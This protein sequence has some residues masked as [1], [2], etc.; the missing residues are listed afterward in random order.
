MCLYVD[1]KPY[2]GQDMISYYKVKSPVFLLFAKKIMLLPVTYLLFFPSKAH[3]WLKDAII[4]PSGPIRHATEL[5]SFRKNARPNGVEMIYTDDRPDH[6]I[7]F[8]NV[9][10]AWLAY[11]ILSRCD[12]LIVGRTSPT[13]SWMNPDERVMLVLNMTMQNCALGRELMD[14]DFEKHMTRCSN[15]SS[16]RKLPENLDTLSLEEQQQ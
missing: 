6:N 1:I 9:Q 15:M 16:V 5:L 13:Q 7:H 12:A 4:Q 10:I 11:F 2:E 14:E 3:V 8:L